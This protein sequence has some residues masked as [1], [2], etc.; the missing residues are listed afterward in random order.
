[1]ENKKCEC[2]FCTMWQQAKNE[3]NCLVFDEWSQRYFTSFL[4]PESWIIKRPKELFKPRF[5]LIK[6]FD[7]YE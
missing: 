1:M 6:K 3:K 4:N 2:N 5:V 7:R